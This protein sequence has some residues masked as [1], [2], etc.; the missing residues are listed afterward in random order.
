M[1]DEAVRSNGEAEWPK[2]AIP[3]WVVFVAV[4]VAVLAVS[5]LIW[6]LFQETTGPGEIVHRYYGAAASGDCETAYSL[7]SPTLQQDVG[8]DPFCSG[9]LDASLPADPKI[10]SVTLTGP[11]ASARA[12]AV[13]VDQGDG[14]SMVWSLERLG[15]TWVITSLPAAAQTVP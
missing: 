1:D 8:H 9:T 6:V 13:T 3:N 7:L 4:A 12:A 10:A 5:A 15:D 14:P 11:E 2:P